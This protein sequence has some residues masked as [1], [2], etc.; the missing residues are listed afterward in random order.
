MRSTY[1]L[2]AAVANSE[3]TIRNINIPACRN[4]IHYTPAIYSRGFT[5]SFSRCEKFG[6]KDIVTDEIKYDFADSCRKDESKC[7][8]DG[9]GFVEETNIE[10]K[11]WK[12]AILSRPFDIL[13]GSFFSMVF[14]SYLTSK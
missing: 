1:L 3:K 10:R 7:G 6:E 14:L 11:I 8:K 12:H 2:L 4:C 13:I 9:K 5:S